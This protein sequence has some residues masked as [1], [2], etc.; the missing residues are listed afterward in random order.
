VERINWSVRSARQAQRLDIAHDLHDYVAHDISGMVAQAQAARYA[1][2]SDPVRLAGALER[3]EAVGL[4]ALGAMDEMVAVLADGEATASTRPHA[5]LGDLPGLV[6]RFGSERG[7]SRRVALT[8]DPRAADPSVT[9]R[10]VQTTAHRVVVEALTNVRRHA[11]EATDVAVSVRLRDPEE[12]L[13]VRVANDLTGHRPTSRR[14][15]GGTGVV[16]LRERVRALGGDLTA[17]SDR[18]GRWVL[19][20][21]I[22]LHP[23]GHHG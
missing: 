3:I 18:D 13:V 5:G 9:S 14:A 6:E 21:D 8:Q 23:G 20:A 11:P 22:P 1:F 2:A 4:Q 7:E 16:G 19:Q 17:G 12:R 15:S 10:Q